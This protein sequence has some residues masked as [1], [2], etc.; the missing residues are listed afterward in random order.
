MSMLRELQ[1]GLPGMLIMSGVAVG[2]LLYVIP[3]GSADDMVERS[4]YWAPKK[5]GKS[6][7]FAIC[8]CRSRVVA[9]VDV[10]TDRRQR[11]RGR[12]NQ[13]EKERMLKDAGV[14]FLQ[15]Q[16]SECGSAIDQILWRLNDVIDGTD[17]DA[18]S[19]GR[20]DAGIPDAVGVQKGPGC[21]GGRLAVQGGA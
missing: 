21:E 5:N 8:D 9:V 12:D 17:R 10:K 14:L 15:V 19:R 18:G 6:V 13:I 1:A 16:A 4:A 3:R 20:T 7:D 11:R 2:R